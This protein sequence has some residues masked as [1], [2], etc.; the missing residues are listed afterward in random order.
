MRERDIATQAAVALLAR[1]GVAVHRVHQVA[2]TVATLAVVQGMSE[3]KDDAAVLN[4]GN[5]E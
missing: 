4:Y 3:H 2:D 5:S 1:S